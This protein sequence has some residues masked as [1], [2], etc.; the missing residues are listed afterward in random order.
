MTVDNLCRHTN[1]DL[2]KPH[3]IDGF[4]PIQY[5][6]ITFHKTIAQTVIEPDKTGTCHIRFRNDLKLL[7]THTEPRLLWF[8]D[9]QEGVSNCKAS[10]NRIQ[11]S[12]TLNITLYN[13]LQLPV[14]SP[15]L[16]TCFDA[17]STQQCMKNNS[18]LVYN[19]QQMYAPIFMKQAHEL[20]TGW[21]T[22][23][24]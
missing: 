13:V 1:H 6:I 10:I 11:S 7:Q 5:E 22:C 14:T 3:L 23:W 18:I 20:W 15:S 16:Y 24:S 8:S 17:N 9:R 2:H 4:R 12:K 19:L 21:R